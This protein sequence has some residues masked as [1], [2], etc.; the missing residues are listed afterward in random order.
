M[1]LTSL[2]LA[3]LLLLT[4]VMASHFYGGS[5]TFNPRRNHDGSYKV[6]LRFKATYHSCS[7][8]DYWPCSS[9]DCGNDVSTVT[10]QVDSS[11]NG[12]SWCQS[13]GVIT[14]MLST[15]SPFQL[16]KSSCC[17][18]YNTVTNSG[19]WSLLTYIDLGVR[20][21]TSEPN[22]SPITTTLPFVRVPQNCP[23][24]YNLL[25]F[26]PDG[27]HVRCRFGL[28]QNQECGICNQPAGFILDQ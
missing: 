25:A 14:K 27:D 1:S 21:D 26:D 2:L 5:M 22:R 6:E 4:T 8:Y 11:P 28:G 19:G 20:S 16:L 23:R 24:R 9:G 17:W 15:N 7:E 13:E 18:I 12:N 3:E 10:G